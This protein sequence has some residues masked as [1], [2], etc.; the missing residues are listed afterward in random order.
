MN[1]SRFVKLVDISRNL[2][3]VDPKS[4]KNYKD[5]LDQFMSGFE[6]ILSKAYTTFSTHPSFSNAF[7][8]YENAMKINTG[9]N[10]V[11]FIDFFYFH[12]RVFRD[13]FDFTVHC[14]EMF[15][16][17]NEKV[18]VN[19]LLPFREMTEIEKKKLELMKNSGK[20]FM[21]LVKNFDENNLGAFLESFEKI[22]ITLQEYLMDPMNNEVCRDDYTKK[23]D[24][25][26]FK[27]NFNQN[28]FNLYRVSKVLS[29]GPIILSE[30]LVAAENG[31]DYVVKSIFEEFFLELPVS[32]LIYDLDYPNHAM[33]PQEMPDFNV[34]VLVTFN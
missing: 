21:D 8:K 11:G 4:L 33:F 30:L 20:D 19:P 14:R 26:Y 18:S 9:K 32:I 5:E 15:A 23:F 17:D 31:K 3:S 27:D 29:L 34:E 16:K 25:S 22:S 13:Y 7:L 10:N 6:K 12:N 2:V 1:V 28:T 24:F